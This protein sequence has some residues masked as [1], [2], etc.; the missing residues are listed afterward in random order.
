MPTRLIPSAPDTD[1]FVSAKRRA[2]NVPLMAAR[3]KLTKIVLEAEAQDYGAFVASVLMLNADHLYHL[4]SPNLPTGYSDMIDG[5]TIG[6]VA[7]SCGTAAY[8]GHP[9]YVSDISTDPL[10]KPYPQIRGLAVNAGLLACWS[11]PI[12]YDGKVIGTFAIY[13]REKRSPT[14]AERTLIREAATAA[15]DVLAEVLST[16]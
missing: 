16:D 2:S 9:I 10:W 8:C 5:I 12:S 1:R 13:H 14:L 11:M 7:G 6:P 15:A 3:A 4:A